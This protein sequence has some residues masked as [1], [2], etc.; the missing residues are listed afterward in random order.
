VIFQYN[1]VVNWVLD[2]ENSKVICQ[3]GNGKQ[4]LIKEIYNNEIPLIL[5]KLEDNRVFDDRESE[6]ILKYCEINSVI[7]QSEQPHGF[8][9]DPYRI[10]KK[11]TQTIKGFTL[12]IVYSLVGLL[13]IALIFE[14][15]R[16]IF[17][18]IV[19]GTIKPKK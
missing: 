12:S 4:F 2:K 8:V 17:Y 5:Y 9:A 11:Y 13:I 3:Y 15:L 7:D 16:R 1:F 18:Y 14:I 6:K 10:E 19:L